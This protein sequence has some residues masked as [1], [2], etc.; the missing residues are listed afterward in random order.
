[1]N[2]NNIKEN[3]EVN[4]E[5]VVRENPQIE[6]TMCFAPFSALEH[7]V[8]DLQ[9]ILEQ[10]FLFRQITFYSL[11]KY[12]NV[13]FFDFQGDV[14]FVENLDNYKDSM[15]YNSEVTNSMLY[16]M[17]NYEDTTAEE[18]EANQVYLKELVKKYNEQ[19]GISN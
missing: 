11:S 19:L 6:W 18:F 8:Y 1:M 14:A 12:E 7:V 16:Y 10:E 15:H 17:L 2:I 5:K 3:V 9:G 13:K 4:V